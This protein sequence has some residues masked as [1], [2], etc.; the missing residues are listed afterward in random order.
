MAVR[1]GYGCYMIGDSMSPAYEQGDLLLIHPG[2][3]VRPG[4]DCVFLRE[5]GRDPGRE[6]GREPGEGAP[7]GSQH[8]QVRRLLRNT[9]E[10]FRVRQFNPARD[11]DLDRGQWTKVHLIV[12]KY[13]R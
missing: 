5:P 6:P 12:G 1:D 13:A 9:P 8:T 11:F 7:D 2:K 10:K 4:D 3:P